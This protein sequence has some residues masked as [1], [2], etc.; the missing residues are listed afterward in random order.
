MQLVDQQGRQGVSK[1]MDKEA[2]QTWSLEVRVNRR[3][4]N[5]ESREVRKALARQEEKA[6]ARE[7]VEA[8]G[9]KH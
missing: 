7:P 8:E 1:G 6:R 9:T 3:Q 4:E 5:Q 2:W